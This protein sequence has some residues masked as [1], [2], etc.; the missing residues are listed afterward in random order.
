MKIFES[1]ENWITYR[2]LIKAQG[3]S[4]G[5]VPTMGALHDGHLALLT[6]AQAENEISVVSIYV[7]PTQFNNSE[8][9]EK[10]PRPLAQDLQLLEK[11]NASAVILPTQNEIYAKGFKYKV[12]END[13]S[14]LLCGAH[15]PGH[16]TG[17]LTIVMKLLGLVQADNCYMGEKDYQQY[18]LVK[19]MAEDFFITTN[20]VACPTVRENSGLAMSSRNARLSDIG[21]AKAS[22]IFK[23]LNQKIT[24]DVARL[25]LENL[26]FEVEYL[27]EHWG[28]RFVAVWLEGVR[29]IDNVSL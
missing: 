20:I 28:R 10:Y 6:Q 14:Q 12:T 24:T 16:F 9:L 19:E 23:I 15:R 5:F 18:M 25:K 22:E 4:I 29:L 11:M 13:K 26:G 3:K 21:R 8:D 7:N 1:L 2:D 27:E 17:V